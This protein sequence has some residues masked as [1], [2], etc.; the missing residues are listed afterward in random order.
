MNEVL[1]NYKRFFEDQI[2]ESEQEFVSYLKSPLSSL[3]QEDRVFWGKVVSI[4]ENLG[5]ITIQ[6]PKGHCPRLKISMSFS[7]LRQNAWNELGSNISQWTCQCKQFLENTSYHTMF[8]DIKPL[9]FKKPDESHDYIG[10][11][12][13]DLK[14]FLS[15][16]QALEDGRSVWYLMTETFPPTQYLQNLCNYI[17]RYNGDPELLVMPKISYDDWKPKELTNHDDIAGCIVNK[18][19]SENLCILQGPPGTGESYTIATIVSRYIEEGK[20]VCVTTMSNKGLTEL[21]EKE[22]LNKAREEGKISKTLLTADELKQIKGTKI[23][24]KDLVV[25]SGELLCCT[26]YILSSKYSTN[27]DYIVEPI[28]DLVVIEEASQAYLTSIAAFKR[29][30]RQCLIVGD[31]MQLPP[32]VLNPQKSEYIQWNVDI[33][34]NGLKTYA[35]GTDTSSFRITTSYRLTDESCLLTGLFYQNS[36]KSVQKEAITF[37]KISDKVYFPQKGGT[38]IKHVSGAMDAVCSKAARNTIRSIVT[39]ISENYPKRTIG[40]ISPF[41][42]TVQ[43]LQREFYIENQSIDITVE[44]I[45]RIQGMTVDYTILYFPQRNISFALTENRFNVATSRSRSTTLIISDVPLEIF[46]TIS[47]IVSKYLYSCT[48]IDGNVLTVRSQSSEHDNSQSPNGLK[49]IKKIDLSKF[50]TS[51]QKSVKSFTKENIYIIDTNVF[52]NCPDIIS[53]IDSKYKVVLSAKVIDELDKLKIKLSNDEKRIVETALKLINR[54]MDNENVSMELS[55]PTLLPDDFNKKSP[56][57]NILTVALKFKDENPILLT[58]DNGLQVKAKGLKIT[59][60]TLKEFLK[61]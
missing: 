9:Y 34:A 24:G 59:T 13:V 39:W 30:G 41:R 61:R 52:V 49:V 51:K 32:I 60:I 1:C 7:I 5:H 55:D 16:K 43:E 57:N 25:P 50:E 45:D 54:A 36:L 2:Q 37:E 58:S 19:D 48:H 21:I 53:K 31:P 18:L 28:Y 6:V 47:P 46:T 42:Q 8:S 12:G 38:I 14:L 56:D 44:T 10:C 22:P 26:Y 20:T 35:L 40:I 27:A 4:N 3:F 11:S 17:D 23:A 33:Q 29:L 15:I